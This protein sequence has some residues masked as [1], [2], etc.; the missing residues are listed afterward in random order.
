MKKMILALF[1]ISAMFI[2][3]SC[4]SDD[5]ETIE[6]TFKGVG[7]QTI[8][9]ESA[10]GN[11]TETSAKKITLDELFKGSADYGAPI[12]GWNY[13]LGDCGF[14]VVGLPEGT[15]LENF[16]LKINGKEKSFGTVTT[17]NV[18]LYSAGN[19]EFKFFQEVLNDVAQ[20]K[21][22][23]TIVTFKPTQTTVGKNIKLEIKLAGTCTYLVE[24]K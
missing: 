9:L 21:E 24:V 17:K 4:G 10:A 13:V 18:D 20:K 6:K 3:S 16:T 14:K 19:E 1:T 12:V 7:T 11:K 2:L 8:A 15:S 23:E 5:P 22:I